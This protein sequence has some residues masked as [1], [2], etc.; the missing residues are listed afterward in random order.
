MG[1]RNYKYCIIITK[2][3]NHNSTVRLIS[4][5]ILQTASKLEHV[6]ALELQHS[7]VLEV[8]I[9][10]PVH[11]LLG[12]YDFMCFSLFQRTVCS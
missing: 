11:Y 1:D 10:I 2:W 4:F 8:L 6:C 12:Y 5:T 3:L 9:I 7:E